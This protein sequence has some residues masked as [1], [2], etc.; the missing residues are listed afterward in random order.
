VHQLLDLGP[1]ARVLEVLLQRGGVVL[2][3]LQDAL[4]D[5][6]LDDAGNLE[7]EGLVFV[8]VGREGGK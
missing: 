2:G 6:V 7:E 3:L 5:G 8:W 4:H 1:D